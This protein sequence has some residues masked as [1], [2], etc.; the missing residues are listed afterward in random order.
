ML[1]N[2][3]LENTVELHF[4]PGAAGKWTTTGSSLLPGGE[5]LDVFASL[6]SGWR[7]HLAQVSFDRE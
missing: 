2:T 7:H 4:A 6:L 5:G 1:K 3:V